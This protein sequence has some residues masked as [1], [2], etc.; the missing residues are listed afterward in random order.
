MECKQFH[1]NFI[2]IHNKWFKDN[3]LVKD[4]A[5]NSYIV[6]TLYRLSCCR[7]SESG[8]EY[9]ASALKSNPS[10]MRQLDL[11]KN[12]LKDLGVKRLS[13]ALENPQCGLT[14]LR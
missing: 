7:L 3:I 8:C 2:Y 12:K 14:T 4:V 5:F 1:I 10:H 6:Y 9:L 13:A 11:S